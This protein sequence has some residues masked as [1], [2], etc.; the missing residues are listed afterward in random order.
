MRVADGDGEPAVVGAND[1]EV[2][3]GG[4]ADVEPRVLAR[5]VRLILL[6]ISRV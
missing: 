2:E 4:A 5:V 3:A 6:L 1:V